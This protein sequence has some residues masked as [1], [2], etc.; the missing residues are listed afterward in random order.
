M[1]REITTKLRF[2]QD[3]LKQILAIPKRANMKL[4]VVLGSY[5]DITWT[6]TRY[7]RRKGGR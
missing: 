7:I 6:K 3:E 5:L 4:E 2:G 1:I